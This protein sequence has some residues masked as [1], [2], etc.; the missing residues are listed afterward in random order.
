MSPT[1][2]VDYWVEVGDE[3]LAD[4]EWHDGLELIQKM[5]AAVP[6]G[7][8]ERKTEEDRR[9]TS[10]TSERS[11]PVS[12][13]RQVLIG[14]RAIVTSHIHGRVKYR[15]WEVEPWPV[16]PGGWKNGGWRIRDARV[17]R[18]SL[19]E[20]ERLTHVHG[21]RLRTLIDQQPALEVIRRGRWL[22]LPKDQ[23]PELEERI[24]IYQKEVV[25]RR[26]AGARRRRER[27]RATVT[28]PTR[29]SVAQLAR[30]S[31]IAPQTAH[32]LRQANPQLGWIEHGRNHYLPLLQLPAWDLIVREY[33]AGSVR[34]R[35]DANRL[36]AA[37]K[38][39]GGA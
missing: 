31:K 11:R 26:R 21:P 6:P 29:M 13:I 9:H 4:G 28:T 16:P 27:E 36:I 8:A 14:Q 3:L 25:N 22:Y 24:K 17:R 7:V 32:K 34:R 19:A 37:R 35:T 30:R 5:C 20:L 23:L 1:R 15:A 39:N 2:A 10:G 12:K 33:D 38:I 18:L